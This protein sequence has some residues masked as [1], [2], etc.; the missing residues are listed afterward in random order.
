MRILKVKKQNK[1][2]KEKLHTSFWIPV[3][4]N[5]GCGLIDSDGEDFSAILNENNDGAAEIDTNN[6]N[7]NY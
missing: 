1:N 5:V 7:N 4:C 3:D 6:A 2:K